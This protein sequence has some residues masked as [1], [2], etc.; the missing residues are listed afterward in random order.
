MEK[1][2]RRGSKSDRWT[3]REEERVWVQFYR[4]AGDPVIAADL[5]EQL[6]SDREVKARHFGLY[7]RCRQ[8][9]RQGKARRAR[10]KH[11]ARAFH[12]VGR[13]LIGWPIEVIRDG[14]GFLGA[15]TVAWAGTDEPAV[16]QMRKFRRNGKADKSNAAPEEAVKAKAKQA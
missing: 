4:K 15:V 1:E 12:L 8:S 5:I 3:S 16:R 6:E 2:I 9:L 13:L 10:A 7:L 14:L 11:V